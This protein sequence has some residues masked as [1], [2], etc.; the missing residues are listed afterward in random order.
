MIAFSSLT[1]SSASADDV[2]S[3]II[4]R[5]TDNSS[6]DLSNVQK[7]KTILVGTTNYIPYSYKDENGQITGL[8]IELLKEIAKR[9][10]WNIDFNAFAFSV[11]SDALDRGQIDIAVGGISVTDERKQKM[12]FTNIYFASEDVVY[13][14]KSL[15]KNNLTKPE[16]F[17]GSPCGR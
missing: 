2:Q 1:F 14:N 16:D 15:D 12:D 7:T 11:R 4:K 5:S 9:N 6:E 8:D 13:A 3:S 17:C 10:N